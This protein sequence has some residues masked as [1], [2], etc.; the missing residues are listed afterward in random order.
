MLISLAAPYGVAPA[1]EKPTALL[2]KN[3]LEKPTEW[4]SCDGH[5]IGIRKYDD[6]F[7]YTRWDADSVNL[8]YLCV[9]N[10]F[11][12][13]GRNVYVQKNVWQLPGCPKGFARKMML[14]FSQNGN[15]LVSDSMQ[16]KAGADMWKKFLNETEDRYMYVQGANGSSQI[17]PHTKSML[18]AFAYVGNAGGKIF[19][20]SDKPVEGRV[21]SKW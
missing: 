17:L 4:D 12:H 6:G 15:I 19:V 20:V 21:R 13:M 5:M 11:E 2:L 16:R 7:I 8:L 3:A 1:R 18:I 9:V 10:R 14:Y